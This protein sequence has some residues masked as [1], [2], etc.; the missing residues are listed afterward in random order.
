MNSPPQSFNTL[1]IYKTILKGMPTGILQA[2]ASMFCPYSET[3]KSHVAVIYSMPILSEEFV[4]RVHY[5]RG[6]ITE[7]DDVISICLQKPV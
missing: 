6:G 3:A 2:I 1:I 4:L 7:H 5:L